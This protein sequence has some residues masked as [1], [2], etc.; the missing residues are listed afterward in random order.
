MANKIPLIAFIL[1]AS[2]SCVTSTSRLNEP[3]S[4]SSKM[5]TNIGDLEQQY[6][7]QAQD[8]IITTIAEVTYAKEFMDFIS[9]LKTLAT[10]NGGLSDQVVQCVGGLSNVMNNVLIEVE[11]M[12]NALPSVSWGTETLQNVV[13][14]VLTYNAIC[15]YALESVDGTIKLMVQRKIE[16]VAMLTNDVILRVA[17][18]VV[19]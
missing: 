15:G 7:Q 12:E 4:K 2:I 1:L 3:T 5:E 9:K 10:L 19:H 8:A 16:D 13:E 6:Q 14:V 11:K 18:L 17:Y